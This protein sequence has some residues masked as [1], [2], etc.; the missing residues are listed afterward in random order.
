M[1]LSLG[2]NTSEIRSILEALEVLTRLHIGL[3]WSSHSGDRRHYREWNLGTYC[4]V[5]RPVSKKKADYDSSDSLVPSLIGAGKGFVLPLGPLVFHRPKPSFSLVVA[6]RALENNSAIPACP[7]K[8]TRPYR[9]PWIREQE[10]TCRHA[11]LVS[12]GLHLVRLEPGRREYIG[13]D[14]GA[15][16]HRGHILVRSI[17]SCSMGGWMRSSER[18]GGDGDRRCRQCSRNGIVERMRVCWRCW[19]RRGQSRMW[20]TWPS[21]YVKKITAVGYVPSMIYRRGSLIIPAPRVLDG[22]LDQPARRKMYQKMIDTYE[23]V[24]RHPVHELD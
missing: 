24:A 11:C 5:K 3:S 8:E 15:S 4:R 14:D 9:L 18:A 21:W 20:R 23:M 17:G 19:C 7:L 1:P 6:A 2:A 10:C 12:A 16:C 13:L 22:R